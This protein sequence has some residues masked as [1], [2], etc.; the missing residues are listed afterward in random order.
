MKQKSIHDRIWIIV[1][2]FALGS[3]VSFGVASALMGG[4]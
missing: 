4:T 3:I 1:A 2:L